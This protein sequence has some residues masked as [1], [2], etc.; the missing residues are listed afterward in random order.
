MS[1]NWLFALLLVMC[2]APM[3][4]QVDT[5][6]IVG[7]V[8]DATGAVLPGAS[9]AVTVVSTGTVT[10]SRRA[11]DGTYVATPLKIGEYTISV[12][13][14]GFKSQTQKNVVLQVQDRLRVDFVLQVGDINERVVVEDA[15]PMLQT[16]TSS[17][18]DVISSSQV[19]SL[20]LNGR[21]YTQLAVLTA[22]VSRTDLGDN[23]NNGGSFA[24]NG[25]RATLNNFLLDGIDNN[26]NDNGRNVLQTS[27]DAIAEF[28]VQTN[29]YSAEFGRSGGAVINATIKSGSNDFHGTLSSSSCATPPSTRETTSPIRTRRSRSFS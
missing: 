10:P 8:K 6:T 18:G 1:R 2:P 28:K 24:A 19:T 20:P 14:P 4:A 9:V 11:A 7:T 29:S 23:G 22:G 25:T 3:L 15:P 12:E 26:S 5:G 16:E 27:V 21:D 17:L 13:A